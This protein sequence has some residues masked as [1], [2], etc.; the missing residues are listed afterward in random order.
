ME[1]KSSAEFLVGEEVKLT[2][3]SIGDQ[4]LSTGWS[5]KKSGGNNYEQISWTGGSR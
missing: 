4:P 5:K 2:C 3:E 1:K